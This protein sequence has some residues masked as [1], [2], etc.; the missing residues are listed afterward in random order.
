MPLAVQRLTRFVL[1]YGLV[2]PTIT[3]ACFFSTFFPQIILLEHRLADHID[4]N[5]PLCFRPYS[6]PSR[7]IHVHD[8]QHRRPFPL[9]RQ[10]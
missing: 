4:L 1:F 2:Q 5:L 9:L 10:P 7:H 3:L 8:N 6:S